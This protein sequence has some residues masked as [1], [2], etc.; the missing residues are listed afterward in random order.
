MDNLYIGVGTR[1]GMGA[2]PSQYCRPNFSLSLSF[3]P[4]FL[5]LTALDYLRSDLSSDL[6]S[7]DVTPSQ[8]LLGGIVT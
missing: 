5:D 6:H 4:S 7:R 3:A 8:V 2:M 1:G